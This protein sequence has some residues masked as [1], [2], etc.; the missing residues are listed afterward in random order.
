M[1][2][3]CSAVLAAV[4]QT[5]EGLVGRLDVSRRA[6]GTSPRLLDVGCWDGAG[7]LR[8]S[9]AIHG[10]ASA[11]GIEV[12]EQEAER[13]RA[14]GVEVATLD[15][16]SERFPWPN[17][18]MDVVVAN[19]VFEHLKNIWQPVSEIARVLKPAGHFVI[20]VPNLASLHNRALLALGLQP[21]S[22]RVLGPHV[23]AFTP[24]ALRQY[25]ELG[26]CFVVKRVVGVGFY[27]FPTGL[28]APLARCWPSAS[29]TVIMVARRAGNPDWSSW[30]RYLHEEQA[31][32]LQ[33]H[34]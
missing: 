27:P 30:L 15:L 1:S 10:G 21:S 25:V 22:I 34:Y 24:R 16:E 33:T 14:R 19:Q 31:S 29:H 32:G 4:H 9:A 6:D 7:T 3:R 18:S 20:S 17:A 5:I 13:A 26:G 2:K 28:A 23:R 11:C 8:Y 12:N